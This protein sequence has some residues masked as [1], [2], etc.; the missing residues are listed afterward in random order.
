MG[1]KPRRGAG[2]PG[3][4]G[5]PRFDA[6]DELVGLRVED[7]DV[8]GDGIEK[9][10]VG[11]ERDEG[12]KEIGAHSGGKTEARELAVRAEVVSDHVHRLRNESIHFQTDDVDDE[13]ELR[14]RR[15]GSGAPE[16]NPAIGRRQLDLVDDRPRRDVGD[17]HRL[18]PVGNEEEA[19]PVPRVVR[20]EDVGH[21]TVPERHLADELF[22]GFVEET[23]PVG[24]DTDDEDTRLDGGH[25]PR[26]E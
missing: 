22:R 12:R 10:I 3:D 26:E 4:L 5:V 14:S 6:V 23:D 18:H 11:R 21:G 2:N 16:S 15:V 1:P 17:L 8:V 9:S 13:I 20:A 7:V 19:A 24:P 25:D